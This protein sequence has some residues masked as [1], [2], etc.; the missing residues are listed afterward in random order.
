MA[1]KRFQS[2]NEYDMGIPIQ[3]P[4]ESDEHYYFRLARSANTRLG[5]IESY[6]RKNDELKDII[7]YAYK[8]AM[9]DIKNDGV[10]KGNRFFE[11]APK[12]KD[13]DETNQRQLRKQ[14]NAVLRFLRKPS[15]KKST[16]IQV[17]KKRAKTINEKYGYQINPETGKRE[18]RKDWKNLTW[19]DMAHYYHSDIEQQMKDAGIGSDTRLRALGAVHRIGRNP[20]KIKEAIKGNI[21][22]SKDDAVNQAAKKM[23]ELGMDPKVIF[24][25]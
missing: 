17:Y 18:K 21:R 19:Q 11:K 24:S 12:K 10:G 2:A 14:I 5:L 6:V 16:T 1:K 15:S 4:R 22:L 9:Y 3:K 25:R 23:L 20:D 7:H 13:S 8:D